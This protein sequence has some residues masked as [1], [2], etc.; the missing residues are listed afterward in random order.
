[1][2]FLFVASYVVSECSDT[3]ILF[4]AC[5]LV[6][7]WEVVH[8]DYVYCARFLFDAQRFIVCLSFSL[9]VQIFIFV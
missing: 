8:E 7:L 2:V 5:S 6:S 9:D 3:E 4:M 1:M